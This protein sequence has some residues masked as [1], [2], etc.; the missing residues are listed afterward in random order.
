MINT[1]KLIEIARKSRGM[2][3]IRRKTIAATKEVE[4]G[5]FVV[6]TVD[7][8]RFTFPLG[9][10]KS[11]IFRELLTMSQEEFG[12]PS[13]GPITFPCDASFMKDAANLI[14][15]RAAVAKERAL[16]QNLI[17][18]SS[19]PSFY[20]DQERTGQQLVARAC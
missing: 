4:K 18:K 9:H 6:Y 20:V 5:H 19:H 7:G 12:L 3:T 17:T 2:A 16:L 10:L 14:H 11:Y 13:S 15:Q 1:K 8:H